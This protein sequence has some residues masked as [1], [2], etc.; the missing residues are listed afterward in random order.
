MQTCPPPER[1]HHFLNERLGD[2]DA[3]ALAQHLEA[4]ATCRQTLDQLSADGDSQNWRR[5][6]DLAPRT[7][8]EP[9]ADF[10]RQLGDVLAPGSALSQVALRSARAARGAGPRVD[11]LPTP[12][13]YDI[14]EKRGRGGIGVVYKARHRRLKRTVAL[15]VLL[16]G[17][18][19]SPEERSRFRAEADVVARLSHPNIVQLYEVG[20]QEGCAFLALEFIE[21][22]SLAE[23]LRGTPQPPHAAASLLETLARAMHYAHQ[24]GVVHRDLKPANILLAG[25][26]D[27]GSGVSENTQARSASEEPPS[28]TSE[29]CLLTPKISDFGLAKQ[30]DDVGQTH[31]GQV[32]GTPS[33]MAPEQARGR[34]KEVG[35]AADV[36][37]LGALLYECLTG[38]PPFRGPTPVDTV[39]QVLHDE[40]V[41]PRRL[42]PKVP[43]DLETVCLKCLQK[44]PRKRYASALD[45]AEDLHRFRV[46]EPVR[47]RRVGAAEQG[48]R[49]CRRNPAL[50]GLLAALVFVVVAGFVGITASYL[51]ARQAREQEAWARREEGQQRERAEVHLYYSRIA[52]AEREWLANNV[53]RAEH[54]LDL[55]RPGQPGRGSA[56]GDRRGWEWH[57]LKRLCH[58][59]LFTVRAHSFP[60]YG[61]AFHPDGNTLV[62]A[63]GDPGY[64]KDPRTTPG[65]LTLWDATRFQTIGAFRGHTGQVSSA[66]F[67]RDGAQVLSLGADGSV[68]LWDV[69][70]RQERVVY[71]AKAPAHW[72][73]TSAALSPDGTLLA[74]PASQ[75]VQLLDV[76]SGAAVATL[77]GHP[78]WIG[79][80][81]FSPDGTRL[82]V[83]GDGG[84]DAVHVW[85]VAERRVLCRVAG[86][87]YAVA[88]A[89]DGRL[90]ATLLGDTLKVWD[91]A[92]GREI[93]NLRGHTGTVRGLAWAPPG[94][95]LAS[96]ADDQTVRVWDVLTASEHRIFRG[97]AAAVFSVAYHPDGRRIASGDASGVL[98]V[99]DVARDQRAVA[100]PGTDHLSDVV[101]TADGRCVLAAKTHGEQSQILGWEADTG[102]LTVAHSLEVPPRTEWPLKYVAFSPDGRLYAAPSPRNPAAVRILDV[103]T[104]KE[105]AT[106]L[107][108]Q[109]RVRAVAFS[110]DGRLV[111]SASGEKAS[112][113]ELFVWQLPATGEAQPAPLVL[114]CQAPVQCLAFSPDGR[115]LA[116]GERGIL[117]P[118]GKS[119][120]DGCLSLWDTTTGALRRRWV[121]HPGTVQTV[122]FDPR[123][124]WLASGGRAEDESVRL[125]DADTGT[126]LHVLQGPFTHTGL[127]FSPDGRRLAAVGYDGVVHL[128]D[129]A[130]GHDVLTLRGPGPQR[131]AGTAADSHVAFSRDGSR[132][133]VNTWRGVLVWD[134]RPLAGETEDAPQ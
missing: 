76:K 98:K 14:L 133:A 117:T 67:S 65:E 63:A 7:A 50:A 73:G 74:V 28:L 86:Q 34:S 89:P 26:R 16:A 121:A 41:P 93:A 47:A 61:L 66:S 20:E 119:R 92:S 114:G 127:T 91:A 15:K 78:T 104:G 8:D 106:L 132:L 12:E 128:W 40:P 31:T 72:R 19:A 68:R 79:H 116:A 90:L 13:G 130:T 126:A 37:A 38:R 5:L 105:V 108:H 48:W 35:P 18:D 82:A 64:H 59:D 87:P 110:C 49:W 134:A 55:C 107:G 101:F 94:R 36:Y 23:Q 51:D 54:L 10:L 118:D 11:P 9:R 71:A 70:S 102:R 96:A 122:A 113:C 21:G 27:Q 103:A 109:A 22:H 129:P 83:A 46:G 1:L 84:E 124:R 95:F 69:A 39:M 33:Y 52:L 30:L 25:V 17:G 29:P 115:R 42:Q 85:Q 4:C 3:A 57:Y 56:G 125:W 131:G 44:E 123:G 6:R 99:W 111:A 32:L 97:H 75:G 100:L 77:G 45:L 24:H 88:F 62:S 120:Q 43:R 81:V 53:T 112:P 60:V 80:V 58:A 2:A